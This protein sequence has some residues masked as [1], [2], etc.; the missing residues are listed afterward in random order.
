MGRKGN[1]AQRKQCEQKPGGIREEQ[2]LKPDEGKALN[3]R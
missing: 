1:S 3:A 2:R